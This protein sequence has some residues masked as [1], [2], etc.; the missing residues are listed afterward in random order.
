MRTRA[1]NR[2]ARPDMSYKYLIDDIAQ[3]ELDSVGGV[4]I[5]YFARLGDSAKGRRWANRFYRAY[6]DRINLLK[7]DPHQFGICRVYPFNVVDTEYRSF[8]VGWFTV[9]YTVAADSFTVWHVRSSRS[10]FTTIRQQ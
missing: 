1:G 10:D 3:A 4:Y 8:V 2:F 7:E 5:S 9:F 6:R